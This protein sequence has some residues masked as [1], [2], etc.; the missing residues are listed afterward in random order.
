MPDRDVDLVGLKRI[1]GGMSRET[2]FADVRFDD[3]TTERYTVRL[4][5]ESGSVAPA[6]LELE[7]K[8]LDSLQRTSVPAAKPL[9]FEEDAELIG[10]APFYVRENVAGTAAFRE[11][12]EAGAEERRARIG[13][14]LAEL[15]AAVHTADW[16]AAG[17]GEF[18]AVPET[19][20]DCALLELRKYRAYY[21][22]NR[23]EPQPVVAEML[24]WLARNAPTS[25]QRVSLVWGDVGL[26][27]FIFDDHGITALTDWEQ[28]HL[29]DPMKDWAFAIWRGAD[30][31]LPRE[32]MFEIYESSSGLKVDTDV[33]DYYRPFINAM[34]VL[35]SASLIPQIVDGHFGDI[36]FARLAMG[37]PFQ[38]LEDGYA[39]M[40]ELTAHGAPR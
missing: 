30:S 28:A 40:R 12:F 5:H 16:K 15:L 14:Q 21:E 39:A 10:R 17:F 13:R 11:L 34:N 26:G 31:L 36:T 7:F 22:R 1:S 32:E 20:E 27:N 8:V 18:M 19:P 4:N 23:I 2:W 3:G 24:S 29:G 37:M 38:C 6:P 25:V 33:V 9:W 35:T